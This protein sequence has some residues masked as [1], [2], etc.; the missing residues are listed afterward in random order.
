MGA[1]C[2]HFGLCAHAIC[3][4]ETEEDEVNDTLVNFIARLL[5]HR[6]GVGGREDG[7]REAGNYGG[8]EEE[9]EIE[10]KAGACAPKRI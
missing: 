4:Q 10:Q 7:G 3:R 9:M 8:R 6:K 5:Q 1:A 2:V